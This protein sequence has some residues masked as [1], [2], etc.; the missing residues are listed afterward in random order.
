MSKITPSELLRLVHTVTLVDVRK[1]KARDASGKQ[2]AGSIYRHPFKA[3]N[4]TAELA[5]HQLVI[6][7][8]HG[9]EVSQAVCGFLR[10][11]GVN[12]HYVEG[13]MA[14]LVEAGFDTVT[15]GNAGANHAEGQ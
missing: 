7:C 3:A 8:V 12:C 15:M 14:A 1:P 9:H 6:Y 2:I 11:E 13:G 5:S 10:D 4:W